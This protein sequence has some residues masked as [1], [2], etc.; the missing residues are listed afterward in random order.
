MLALHVADTD[1]LP[2][3]QFARTDAAATLT[4]GR[5]APGL[6]RTAAICLQGAATDEE[7]RL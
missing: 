4:H 5:T 7:L 2:M 3:R 6:D 1:R